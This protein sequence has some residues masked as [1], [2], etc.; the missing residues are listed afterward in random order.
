MTK[1]LAAYD[2]EQPDC[3]KMVRQ[4]VKI[5]ERHEMPATFFIVAGL[6]DSQGRE[7][8][9]LLG[10]HPL[11]EIASHSYTHQML[12]DN[13]ICGKAAPAQVFRREL[14]ES[15]KRLEDHFGCKLT[16]FRTPVG[17]SEGLRG[18]PDVLALCD[19]AG[20]K[21]VS[22]LLWG[23]LD[24]MP[25]LPLNPFTYAD[26]GYPGLLEIPSA[27]WHENLLKWKQPGDVQPLL[28]FPYPLSEPPVLRHV[29]TPR[30][31]F[32]VHRVFIDDAVR[33]KIAH[34]SLIWHPWSLGKFDPR[35]QM[36]EMLFKYVRSKK[37]PVSTFADFA[38]HYKVK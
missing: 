11:F 15:K 36:L 29:K 13:R 16:G 24:S 33:K 12:R 31:E 5:H 34:V 27:G 35:G 22:T 17:F 8:K 14:V 32:A 25:A 6:L 18:L 19:E 7:Y 28:L 2:T 21:Y 37:L 4:I 30:E 26:D 38:K 23:P 9:S 10:N 3:L 1:Y 20:Y